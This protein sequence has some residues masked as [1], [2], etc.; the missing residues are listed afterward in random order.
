VGGS[1]AVTRAIGDF[2][3]VGKN[4]AFHEKL[5]AVTCFPDVLIYPKSDNLKA[6]ALMSDGIYESLDMET[7]KEIIL[8]KKATSVELCSF[9]VNLA[10]QEGSSDNVTFLLIPVS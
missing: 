2:E 9:I 3:F 10:I 5:H 1:L 4:G 8:T 7:I 6:V